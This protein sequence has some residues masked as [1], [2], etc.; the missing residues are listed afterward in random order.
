MDKKKATVNLTSNFKFKDR[1][2]QWNWQTSPESVEE[3]R[4]VRYH[5]II[6]DDRFLE[7]K[8]DKIISNAQEKS[9]INFNFNEIRRMKGKFKNT[10]FKYI[11]ASYDSNCTPSFISFNG[12]SNNI[13]MDKDLVERDG[14]KI[15]DYI[16][17]TYEE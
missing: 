4:L 11:F 10:G 5:F 8:L 12:V 15:E 1:H 2:I 13:R 3:N 7:S 16:E 6:V 17:R 9:I 14:L